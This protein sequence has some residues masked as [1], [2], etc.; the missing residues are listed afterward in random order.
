MKD[1]RPWQI[2]KVE[3]LR[4]KIVMDDKISSIPLFHIVSS[5]LHSTIIFIPI[6]IDLALLL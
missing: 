2:R 1:H 5:Q 6:V 4:K 3:S